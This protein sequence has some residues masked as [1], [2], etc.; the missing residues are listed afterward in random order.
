MKIIIA[1]AGDIGFHLAKLMVLEK[2]DIILIDNDEE[3]LDF[4]RTHLDVMTVKGDASSLQVLKDASVEKARLV[5]AATTSEK[6]NLL[7]A[8]LAKKMGAKQ[9]IARVQN[10]DYLEEHQ[11]AIFTELGVDSLIS[12]LQLAAYEILRLIQQCSLSDIF[13]FEK[14]KMSLIGFL[15]DDNSAIVNMRISEIRQEQFKFDF[16]PIMILRGHQTL[17]PT[18]DSILRRND[19]IY[20]L[21]QKKDIDSLTT[22]IGKENVNVKNIMIIGGTELGLKTAQILENDYNVIIIEKEK[23][24]CKHLVSQLH[25]SLVICADASNVEQLREEGLENMDA[26][27]ALSNNSEANIISSLVGEESGVYKTIALVSNTEYI[28]LSQNIGVDTLINEKLIAANNIFRF[29]RK[30]NVEALASIHGASAEIIEFNIEKG[31]RVTKKP[32]NQLHLPKTSIVGGVIRGD[33]C[34]F[35]DGTFQLQRHDKVIV[36][37]LPEAIPSIERIFR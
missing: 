27:I 15:L 19:H 30:G 10:P 13:E 1:G 26:L 6:T 31:N 34:I 5:I 9:T 20:F 11:K 21:I 28:R 16:R 2:Q 25:R 29:I 37:A 14:G 17:I 22:F 18:E 4:A 12:T 24:R 8:I 35:P 7:T 3:A 36:F 32:L 23:E 33:E